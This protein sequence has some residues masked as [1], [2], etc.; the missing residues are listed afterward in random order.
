MIHTNGICLVAAVGTDG[1]LSSIS[2]TE[3][4][5][6]DAAFLI[7]ADCHFII[8]LINVLKVVKERR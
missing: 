2:T 7:L 6:I 5:G 1:V 8:F 3:V 4:Y